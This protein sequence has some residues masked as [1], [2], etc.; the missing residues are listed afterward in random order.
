MLTNNNL[1]VFPES[2]ILQCPSVAVLVYDEEY[3][4]YNK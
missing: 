1:L 4:N 2:T 3:A